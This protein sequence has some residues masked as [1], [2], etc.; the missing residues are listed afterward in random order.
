[1]HVVDRTAAWAAA[2]VVRLETVRVSIRFGT[3]T[4]VSG[5]AVE[6]DIHPPIGP[7]CAFGGPVRG[8][9]RGG[10]GQGVHADARRP[11]RQ[12][13]RILATVPAKPPVAARH[14]GPGARAAGGPRDDQA[15]RRCCGAAAL[16]GAALEYLLQDARYPCRTLGR[17]AVVANART[18]A[19]YG[20]AVGQFLGWRGFEDGREALFQS[21]DRVAERLTGRPL[22]RRGG[23]GHDQAA[24]GRRRLAALDVLSHVPGDGDHGVPLERGDAR[25][26]AADR[27]ARVAQDDEALRPDGGHGDRRRDRAYRDLNGAL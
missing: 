13:V 7:A 12:L 25:A 19:A 15:A 4:A 18:R 1:M 17:S 14:D 11:L 16:D 22:T 21:V 10:P 2:P 26:R 20:R 6:P 27:G 3:S 9:G 5:P 8:Y 24:V 23:S